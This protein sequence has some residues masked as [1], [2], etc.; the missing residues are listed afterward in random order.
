MTLPKLALRSL[1]AGLVL[2]VTIPAALAGAQRTDYYAAEIL[3]RPLGI[4]PLADGHVLITDAGG[5]F[6][7]LTDDAILEVDSSGEVVWAYVGEMSFPHSAVLLDDG[8]VLV[9]DTANDRVFRVDR[10]GQIVWSSD[11]WGSGQGTLSDGSHLRYPNDAELLEN[12]HLLITDRNNDRAV[13]VTA[14]GQIAWQ[15]DRL[16]RPHNADRLPN[17]NTLVCNSEDNLV[18]E[19]NPQGQVVWKFGDAFPL[20]WPRD[21]DRLDDGNTLVTDSRNGRVLEVTPDGQVVWSYSGL[22][23]PYEADRLD[24][25]DTLIADNDHMQV[26]QVNR[27]GQVVWK[28]RNFPESYRADLQNGG[29]ETAADG[30][31]DSW[32]PAD[33]N[34]EGP[35]TFTWDTAAQEGAHSAG[36]TYLGQGR[37]SWLQVVAVQPG[38]VYRFSGFLRTELRQGIAAYQ[39]W[40]LDA[41]GGPLGEVITVEPTMQGASGWKEATAEVTAPEGAAAVQIWCQL[42]AAD[43]QAWFDGVRWERPGGLPWPWIGAGAGGLLLAGA[44]GLWLRRRARSRP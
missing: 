16:N 21:A 2:L 26:I 39:L 24:S 43:G 15:Y 40:F 17:G 9:S 38:Q 10:S 22:A 31:P 14:D 23:L 4:Q 25:G 34:A 7:T 33:M 11:D 28:F 8:T 44:A 35:V 20:R 41:L 18:L 29:F 5:A 3:D 36:I 42:V 27:E 37:G 12:G 30:L 19:V 1:L 13:E 32:Y 6:Y